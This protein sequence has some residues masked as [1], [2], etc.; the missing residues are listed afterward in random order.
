MTDFSIEG[1]PDFIQLYE[2]YENKLNNDQLKHSEGNCKPCL[3]FFKHTGCYNGFD[4][5][6]FHFPHD[7]T[8]SHRPS[9]SKRKQLKGIIDDALEKDPNDISKILENLKE[10]NHYVTQLLKGNNR[11]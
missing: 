7:I 3:F 1:L 4:C 8:K 5:T 2:H 9:K 10:D 6:F 11:Q